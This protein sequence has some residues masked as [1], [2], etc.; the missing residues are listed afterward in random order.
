M[1]AISLGCQLTG[2]VAVGI[3]PLPS[4]PQPALLGGTLETISTD[5]QTGEITVTVVQPTRVMGTYSVPSAQLRNGPVNLMAPALMAEGDPVVG[6]ALMRMPGLWIYDA[7]LGLPNVSVAWQADTT[8]DGTFAATIGTGSDTLVTTPAQSDTQVRVQETATQII[9]MATS[10][11]PARLI[12]ASDVSELQAPVLLIAPNVTGPELEST[13][14][15]VDMTDSWVVSD[16]E[17]AVTERNYRLFIDGEVVISMQTN[18]TLSLPVDSGGKTYTVDIRATIGGAW[19]DW[20]TIAAGT[21]QNVPSLNL[22]ANGEFEIDNANGVIEVT[23]SMPADYA[24][25]YTTNTANLASGPINLVPPAIVNS[26]AVIAGETLSAIPGLWLYDPDIGGLGPSTY[27][28][29]VDASGNAEYTDLVGATTSNYTVTHGETGSSVRIVETLSDGA[30]ATTAVSSEV[31]IESATTGLSFNEPFDI[32]PNM[33]D[34]ATTSADWDYIRRD[35]GTSFVYDGGIDC[36][37]LATSQG[38]SAIRVAHSTLPETD[39]QFAEMVYAGHEGSG[40]INMTL[41]IN[42]QTDASCYEVVYRRSNER[43]TLRK[44][45]GGNVNLGPAFD[46]PRPLAAGDKIRIE[47]QGS[48]LNA[49]WDDGDGFTTVI[50]GSDDALSGGKI[51]FGCYFSNSNR[52]IKVARFAGG[53]K[54]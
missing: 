47:R 12:G 8:N 9:G 14:L 52:A 15:V 21:V 45:S 39:N 18:P 26:G 7:A 43:L 36:A 25:T 51:S 1:R 2:A 37:S 42:F 23:I 44:V 41:S 31:S 54:P 50:T 11:S 40:T 13:D 33:A 3:A 30:G 48:T 5:A 29:Q 20:T 32:Y 49:L 38:G 27:Q 22:T 28:W 10:Q 46:L 4:P 35:A 24:G 17:V 6:D 53:D 16:V 34:I 19:S